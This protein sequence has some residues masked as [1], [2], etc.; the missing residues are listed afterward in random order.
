MQLHLSR[1]KLKMVLHD[2][3]GRKD[4]PGEHGYGIYVGG[5][6]IMYAQAQKLV[7]GLNKSGHNAVVYAETSWL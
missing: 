1:P 5:P 7:H 4:C 2:V 3:V 6:S